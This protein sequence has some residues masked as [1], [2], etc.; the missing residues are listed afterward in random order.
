MMKPSKIPASTANTRKMTICLWRISFPMSWRMFCDLGIGGN[1]KDKNYL[2]QFVLSDYCTFSP[3]LE[4]AYTNTVGLWANEQ[5]PTILLYSYTRKKYVWVC[6][7]VPLSKCY[8]AVWLHTELSQLPMTC[9]QYCSCH[10]AKLALSPHKLSKKK[11]TIYASN[12]AITICS[13]EL[14]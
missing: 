11:V 10:R 1:C 7:F 9:A 3:T 4:Y 5:N 2:Y 8:E 6:V 14:K 13:F 12:Q